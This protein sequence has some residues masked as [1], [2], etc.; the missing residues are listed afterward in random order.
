MEFHPDQ[1]ARMGQLA[2]KQK[3][4]PK[5]KREKDTLSNKKN[6]KIKNNTPQQ[7]KNK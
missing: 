2:N 4:V 5:T 3:R 1:I 7:S 6:D